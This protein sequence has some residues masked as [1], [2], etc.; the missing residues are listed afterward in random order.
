MRKLEKHSDDS[1]L[2]NLC[3]TNKL[4]RRVAEELLYNFIGCAADY[5]PKW[6]AIANNPLLTKHVRTIYIRF[7]V[8][9]GSEDSPGKDPIN[10][11]TLR[12]IFVKILANAGKVRTLYLKE[13][14]HWDIERGDVAH[15]LGWLELL[16][17]AVAQPVHGLVN[18]FAF[19]QHLSIATKV[20]SVQEISCV[21]RLPSLKSLSIVS[22]H[23]TT[24]FKSWSIPESSSPIRRLSLRNALM[25]T[26]AVVQ[27]IST[28]KALHSF[29]YVRSSMG[30]EPFA[31]D[32]N[33]LSL[34]PEHSWKLL[35]DALRTH[36]DS[37]EELQVYDNCDQEILNL[38]YPDGQDSGT[39][40]SFRDF[41]ELAICDITMGTLLNVATGE[42]DLSLYLPPHLKDLYIKI[43]PEDAR[44]LTNCTS[45]LA[46]LRS[47]LCAGQEVTVILSGDLPL[48]ALELSSTFA[49]LQEAGIKVQ[50]SRE[51]KLITLDE[52]RRLESI[53]IEEESGEESGEE[54]EEE[55]G[56]R[57]DE[58]EA[59]DENVSEDLIEENGDRL[60]SATGGD[61]EVVGQPE[62]DSEQFEDHSFLLPDN[63]S[64]V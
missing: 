36:R 10:A 24:P 57:D 45:A 38:I 33:P 51:H 23:Q 60:A 43:I 5:D 53:E 26:S 21:F 17:G 16:D 63:T 19:L 9:I 55:D 25:D 39:L 61:E 54:E 12:E 3:R 64:V 50:I 59:E 11:E 40:G 15:T 27:M 31:A 49:V 46:S 44:F 4:C 30:W 7:G 14:G 32:G 29:K 20:L 6:K 18:R 56:N 52:L 34:W 22:V 41:P 37:L 2:A 48:R 47:V 8:A 42:Y 28:L 62:N 13:T 35:G 58:V 1:V